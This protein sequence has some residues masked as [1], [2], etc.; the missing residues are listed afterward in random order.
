MSVKLKSADHKA[1]DKF[2]G[3]VLDAYAQG[4]VSRLAAIGVLAH[5][6]A[7]AAK[8]NEGEVKA[9]FDKDQYERWLEHANA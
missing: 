3:F 7:A 5:V 6:I 9:W 1:M 8:D 4:K 2:L